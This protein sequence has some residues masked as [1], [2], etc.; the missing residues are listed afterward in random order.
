MTCMNTIDLSSDLSFQT[1]R[2]G[3]KGGQNVNKV[4]TAVIASFHIDSSQILNA[5]QKAVVKE[6]LGNRI[7]SEGF[8]QVRSQTHRTQLANK[9]ESIEKIN[10]LVQKALLKKKARIATKVSRA[11]KEKRIESK[12][13]RADIKSGRQRPRLDN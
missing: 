4:E 5:E 3:G 10:E 12:K 9:E 2:S 8:L 1:T 6:K 13:R 7:N 11:S